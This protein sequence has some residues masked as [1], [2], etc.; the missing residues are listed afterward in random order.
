MKY[1]YIEAKDDHQPEYNFLEVYANY[2]GISDIKFIP[3][4]GKDNLSKMEN[5]MHQNRLEGN[6]IAILFDADAP[7]NNGG[8][9]KRITEIQTQLLSIRISAPIFLWPNNQD[10]GDFEVMLE[11]VVR[12]D[13]H[14]L[15]FD[16]FH[17]YESC[18]ASKYKIP[19]RKGKFHTFISAQKGL[20]KKQRD[21][22]GRGNWL[23]EDNTLWNLESDYLES[24]KNFLLSL[25]I[26]I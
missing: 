4:N 24:L 5:H 23:F 13:E 6:S 16:C 25:D 12:Q 17:D 3:I 22:I 7:S 10:D 15:F 1:V 2:I 8:Y 14:R 11:K 26:M 9:A 18:V 20:C 21:L 19:N